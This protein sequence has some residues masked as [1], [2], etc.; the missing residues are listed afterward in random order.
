MEVMFTSAV[1]VYCF[2]PMGF[3]CSGKWVIRMSCFILKEA[4][5]E[6]GSQLCLNPRTIVCS[7]PCKSDR[8]HELER[9]TED[10]SFFVRLICPVAALIAGSTSQCAL[11]FPTG[12]LNLL[13]R[14]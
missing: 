11:F 1:N 8:R 12:L 4:P 6:R 10:A 9:L 14:S 5:E 3:A 13:I 2:E 7:G